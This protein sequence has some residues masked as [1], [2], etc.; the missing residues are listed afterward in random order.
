MFDLAG[1]N[2]KLNNAEELKILFEYA[3][4]QG[5]KWSNSKTRLKSSFGMDVSYPLVIYFRKDKKT[6]CWDYVEN[7]E[8]EITDFKD[9]E[10]YIKSN[11]EPYIKSNKELT[12]GKELTAREFVEWFVGTV[13]DYCDYCNNN[14]KCSNCKLNEFNTKCGRSLCY[15]CNW[16][17]N[18]DELLEI[19]K[20]DNLSILS[21]KK[22]IENIE[23]LIKDPDNTRMSNEL[24]ES[25][26]LAVDK[27]KG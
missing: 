1:K 10:P 12:A 13:F 23:K 22:A 27:L 11:I 9:I 6:I 26:K 7:I 18:I 3:D 4:E 16:G 5:W 21:E 19:A 17:E 24:I 15:T 20:Q 25:L 2:I 8:D 14:R